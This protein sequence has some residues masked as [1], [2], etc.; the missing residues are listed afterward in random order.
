MGRFPTGLHVG[1]VPHAVAHG[2]RVRVGHVA[3]RGR[4]L[5]LRAYSAAWSMNNTPQICGV[6]AGRSKC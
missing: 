3:P 6:S 5:R 1:C 4:M 2:A